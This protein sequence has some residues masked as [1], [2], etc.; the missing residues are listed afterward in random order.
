MQ[1]LVNVL[2]TPTPAS[3]LAAWLAHVGVGG[4]PVDPRLIEAASD[5]V[6][7]MSS[8]PQGLDGALVRFGSTL[9]ADGWPIAQVCQWLQQLG[10]FVPRKQRKELARFSSHAAVAQGWAEG[11]VR[12]AHTGMC[13]DPTTGLV[14]AMV[15]QLRMREIYQ[16]CQAMGT[17][18][19]ELHSLVIIDIDTRG[20]SR[21][22]ADLLVSCVADTV[23][24][25][26]REG[27]TIARASHRILVLAAN[28]EATQQRAELLSDRLWLMPATR[29]ANATV[30][31]DALPARPELL[32]RYFH[33]LVG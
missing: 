18:P 15:L 10:S 26:F 13:V 23:L 32:E 7:T 2:H 1:R 22:E 24:S 25:S 6:E 19:S 8:R 14:T 11:F 9:G 16:Q 33:D 20:D 17:L 31:V 27:E 5:L 3:T 12:G 21:L 28:S 4:Q 29:R 30:T